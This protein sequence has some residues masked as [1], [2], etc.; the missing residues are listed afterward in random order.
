MEYISDQWHD[1]KQTLGGMNKRQGLQQLVNLGTRWQR[2]C[3]E[4]ASGG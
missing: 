3:S 1:M 4:T 2:R